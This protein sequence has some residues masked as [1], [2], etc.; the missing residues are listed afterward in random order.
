MPKSPV[1]NEDIIISET[2]DGETTRRRKRKK[3][4]SDSDKKPA[5][6]FLYDPY[7]WGIYATLFVV[8]LIE[9]YSAS[10]KEIQ[11]GHIYRPLV[12]HAIQLI[13]GTGIMVVFQRIHYKF[14]RKIAWGFAIFAFLLL[15]YSTLFG[16]NINGAQR[17]IALP[18]FTIQPAEIIKLAVVLL[19]AKI[20]AKNQM[21]EGVT[22]R[23]VVISTCVVTVVAGVLW[24]N[25]LTNTVLLMV[26][27]VSMLLIGGIQGRKFLVVVLIY[28]CLGGM[29]YLVKYDKND[30]T[31]SDTSITNTIQI[32][33]EP[34]KASKDRSETHI[35]R[36]KRHIQGVHPND[37]VTDEN[38][39]AWLSKAAQARGHFTGTGLG[40]SR[41]AARLPL[42]FSDYI[43]AIVVEDSGLVGGIILLVLYLSILARAGTIAA[44]CTRAFPALLIMGCAVLIVFQAL[45]HMGIVTSVF[46]V[47]GQPL[48]FISK[49]GTSILVMSMA[50]GMMLSVS[51]FAARGNNR[52]DNHKEH[53]ELPEDIQA[54]NPSLI[55]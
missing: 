20:L 24:I 39:Q 19:L 5:K 27:S 29:L 36:I 3:E 11:I 45:V 50:M 42:A 47:S 21:K 35:G 4:K 15:C 43:F 12:N 55:K 51:R 17:A 53:R 49:G 33:G 13:I 31:G 44:R 8:S 40:N 37:S 9:L 26:V 54:A 32:D 38:R 28:A 10:A 18:G 23:G 14:F 1:F 52:S 25:G 22:N 46:P 30:N 34:E 16:T 7:L 6:K 41:E 48:P 2:Y